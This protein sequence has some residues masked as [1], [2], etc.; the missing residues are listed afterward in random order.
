MPKLAKRSLGIYASAIIEAML[1]PPPAPKEE[2]RELITAMAAQGRDNYRATVRHDKEFV[3]Y[4]R[5]ATPE[6]ELGKL[7]LGSR[8][9]KRKPQG[10][11]EAHVRFHGYLL[12]HK[13]V[14]Y[15]QAG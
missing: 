11:I 10:G 3:P 9:A 1:F 14:W 4:F 2:W 13:P 5:V 7:P 6:Q 12:G 8:P 15:C